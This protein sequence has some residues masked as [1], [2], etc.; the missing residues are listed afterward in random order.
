MGKITGRIAVNA[1]AHVFDSLTVFDQASDIDLGDYELFESGQAVKFWLGDGNACVLKR[2]TPE[3]A[4]EG[5][6]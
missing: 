3:I 6:V 4:Q 1:F 2:A 5:K